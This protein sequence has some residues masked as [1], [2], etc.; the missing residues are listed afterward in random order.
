LLDMTLV[1]GHGLDCGEI[2]RFLPDGLRM[3]RC[4][5]IPPRHV[6]LNED[7]CAGAYSFAFSKASGLPYI[8]TPSCAD[9]IQA[10]LAHGEVWVQK[11]AHKDARESI[12]KNIRRLVHSVVPLDTA[13]SQ[14]FHAVLSMEPKNTCKPAD[15]LSALFPEMPVS[16]WIV[17]RTECL[18][19]TREGRLEAIK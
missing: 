14:S 4:F 17:C 19:R 15:L 12:K 10:F 2:N 7:I 13:S 3:K 11:A 6:S 18:H 9:R 16:A 8:N 1:S 5:E